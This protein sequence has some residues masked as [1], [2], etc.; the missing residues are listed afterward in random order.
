M[1]ISHIALIVSFICFGKTA[2]ATSFD[3]NKAS[4]YVELTICTTPALSSLDDQLNVLYKKVNQSKPESAQLI[5]KS[6]LSW[7]KDVRNKATTAQ[8]ITNAYTARIND[9]NMMLGEGHTVQVQQS[10][11]AQAPIQQTYPK[12]PQPQPQ[13]Q[14]QDNV[15]P[16]QHNADDVEQ[17][18][19]NIPKIAWEN[20]D[21]QG[22]VE[23]IYKLIERDFKEN[24]NLTLS[25]LK[26]IDANKDDFASFI[27]SKK[28]YIDYGVSFETMTSALNNSNCRQEH[29]ARESLITAWYKSNDWRPFNEFPENMRAQEQNRRNEINA[30]VGRRQTESINLFNQCTYNSLSS[31]PNRLSRPKPPVEKPYGG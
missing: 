18:E 3:C 19:N 31:N 26:K 5:K 28:S 1:K 29:K 27:V 24:P 8:G 2:T 9:L 20:S 23:Q 13:P 4:G 6:Q 14:P 11:P 17:K 12:Q 30:E 21:M 10:T 15:P 7:L 25:I 16:P 22:G